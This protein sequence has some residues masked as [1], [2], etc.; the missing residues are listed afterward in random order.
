MISNTAIEGEEG[1]AKSRSLGACLKSLTRDNGGRLPVYNKRMHSALMSWNM[2]KIGAYRKWAGLLM[3]ILMGLHIFS[4]LRLF[5]PG[6]LL[7]QL[8]TLGIDV[9]A[10][11]SI[12]PERNSGE[13]TAAA[14]EKRSG[15]SKCSCNKQK[16]CPVIPRVAITSNPLQRFNS[17]QR[18]FQSVQYN[19]LVSHV[20]DYRWIQG[21]VRRSQNWRPHTY[22]LRLPFRLPAFS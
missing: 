14:D 18:E 10:L 8:R 2:K 5:C 22:F 1:L 19:S 7:A 6:A 17:V 9:G 11:S 4:G 21:V 13:I 16:K 20:I 15:T 3:A 12:A